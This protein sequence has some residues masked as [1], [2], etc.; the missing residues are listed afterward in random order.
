MPYEGK[1]AYGSFRVKINGRPAARRTDLQSHGAVVG[2]GEPTVVIGGLAAART[3]DRFK[4]TD[5]IP[6]PHVGGEIVQGS[7]DVIIGGQRAAR[8]DD[9]THCHGEG[10]DVADLD[11]VPGAP[12][13]PDEATAKECQA[14]WDKYQKEAE[15]LI[16]PGD[17]DHRERNHIINGAYANL[18]RR[19]PKFV[20]AGLGAY[21]SKQVG[22]A[23]DHSLGVMRD[24]PPPPSD[25]AEYTYERLGEGNR[26]LF[27]DVYP[28][29]RFY[30]EEGWDRFKQCAGEKVPPVGGAMLD[31][32]EALERYDET[33][34]PRYLEDHLR[35]MAYHE[36]VFILQ[37][38]IYN[39][40]A[41]R[42]I[43]DAN[44]GNMDE[45]SDDWV[46]D[47]PTELVELGG[48]KPADVVM[49][50]ECTDT[51]PG[52]KKTIPFNP[53]DPDRNLHDMSERMEW[54]MDDIGGYYVPHQGSK[55]HLDDLDRLQKR[56]EDHGATYP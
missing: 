15:A 56:G 3:F 33:G 20:W 44:E 40:P 34:D 10:F 32:F 47:L 55:D 6:Q 16:A 22:C 30:E 21:A 14:L 37:R 8:Q 42:R 11:A 49:T 51:T 54:I 12:G 53:G 24:Y 52:K 27:L 13:A 17:H 29:H 9:V 1:I 5:A 2:E 50:S 23:M 38:G 28:Q 43:L 4:C 7:D 41:M 46:P 31:A 39:D 19:N 18:Y 36:Q 25:I 45:A 35:A 26:A 48:G